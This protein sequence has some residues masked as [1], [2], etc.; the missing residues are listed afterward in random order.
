MR[1]HLM[2]IA[3]HWSMRYFHPAEG[4]ISGSLRR[5]DGRGDASG[6]QG[7]GTKLGTIGKTGI[8]RKQREIA[9]NPHEYRVELVSAAGFEPATHALKASLNTYTINNLHV[10][11]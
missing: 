6:A 9:G 5:S 10:Q 3:G 1:G 11:L 2:R 8:L 7:A 4:T